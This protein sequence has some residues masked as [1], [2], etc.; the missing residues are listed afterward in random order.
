MSERRTP[1]LRTAG[2]R[3]R[4]LAHERIS[5]QRISGDAHHIQIPGT[6]FD[7]LAVGQWCHIEQMDIGQWWMNIGG[8]T[9][10]VNA[11]RDG[12]A[13]CVTVY[14]PG[15]YADAVTGCKYEIVWQIQ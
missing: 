9:L 11:D 5:G 7:E 8:V 3:W 4:L 15:S 13:K 6:E 10:W 12:R 14:G 1:R 2:S